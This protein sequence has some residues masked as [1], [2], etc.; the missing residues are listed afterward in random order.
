M[1]LEQA[2]AIL[3]GVAVIMLLAVV[4]IVIVILRAVRPG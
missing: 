4:A 1:S 2:V 3:S